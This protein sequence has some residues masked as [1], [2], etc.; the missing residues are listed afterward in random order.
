MYDF[1][2]LPLEGAS[3]YF[4]KEAYATYSYDNE[5]RMLVGYDTL[6]MALTKVGYTKQNK[7]GGAMWWKISGDRKDSRSIISNVSFRPDY[8]EKWLGFLIRP[9]LLFLLL[10]L[11]L[12][13]GGFWLDMD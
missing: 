12:L 8:Q 2:D 4:D 1:K 11:S 5:T 13:L 10:V 6:D 9:L 7:L 3:E